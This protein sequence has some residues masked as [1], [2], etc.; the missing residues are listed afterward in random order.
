MKNRSK[1]NIILWI[2]GIFVSVILLLATVYYEF[3]NISVL[4]GFI[5]GIYITIGMLFTSHW[6]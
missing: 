5:C 3:D 2:V 6:I 1:A 4:I